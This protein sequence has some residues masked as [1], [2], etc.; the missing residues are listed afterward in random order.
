MNY[1][2]IITESLKLSW[3]NRS[4][5]FFGVFIA[6]V[7]G[8]KFEF[9]S[10][11]NL[12]TFDPYDFDF[13]MAELLPWILG[14]IALLL[15]FG[16]LYLIAKTALI[17]A[18]NKLTRGGVYRFSDSFSSGLTYFWRMLGMSFFSY[19]LLLLLMMVLI[20]ITVAMAA[21]NKW[22]ILVAL[23]ID[24]PVFLLG[25]FAVFSTVELGSRAL[26]VRDVSLGD[27]AYEG[28]SLFWTH[29]IES[30]MIFL[31]FMVSSIVIGITTLIFF[32]ILS[33]A[34][35]F[36]GGS[37]LLSMPINIVYSIVVGGM[38]GVFISAL[39]TIFYFR[40]LEPSGPVDQTPVPMSGG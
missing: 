20:V 40:L 35:N 16:A 39:Y 30:F 21:I 34:L 12:E 22:L 23:L 32:G 29:K 5:W 24:L 8:T 7:S 14:A 18:V 33:L 19:G 27:A 37:T 11:L 36:S 28:W 25:F 38:F 4:L 17:D 26:V 9:N 3:K 31:T 10:D 6:G 15:F 13:D 2:K 1:E